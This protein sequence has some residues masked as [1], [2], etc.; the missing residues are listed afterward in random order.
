MSEQKKHEMIFEKKDPS[1]AAEWFCPTCGRRMLISWEPKFR[2]TVLNAGDPDVAH[3]GFRI[4]I[5]VVGNLTF[6]F[7]EGP[8]EEYLEKIDLEIDETRLNLWTSWME[9]SDFH[10]LWKGELP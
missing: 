2:R 9:E 6:P 4:N 1:G 5:P 8:S 3:G 7:V 10:R